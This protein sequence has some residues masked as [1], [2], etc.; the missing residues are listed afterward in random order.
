MSLAAEA[1][2][3]RLAP[4][5]DYLACV[6]SCDE[7]PRI[8]VRYPAEPVERTEDQERQWVEAPRSN[9]GDPALVIVRYQVALTKVRSCGS[10]NELSAIRFRHSVSV[11]RYAR[12]GPSSGVDGLA[13]SLNSMA[14]DTGDSPARLLTPASSAPMGQLWVIVARVRV[15][16][17]EIPAGAPRPVVRSRPE[18]LPGFP[19]R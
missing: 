8:L 13:T 11:A 18:T 17:I 9:E 2:D 19:R 15:P 16:T 4:P 14:S 3:G 6:R 10:A 1:G 5:H 7:D 12:D